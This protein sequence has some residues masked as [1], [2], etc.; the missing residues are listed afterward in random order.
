MTLTPEEGRKLHVPTPLEGRRI[1][2]SQAAEALGVSPWQVRRLRVGIRRDGLEAL[3]HGTRKRHAPAGD[4][5]QL[6]ATRARDGL[7]R[8]RPGGTPASTRMAPV[9]GTEPEAG[10]VGK[11]GGQRKRPRSVRGKLAAPVDK[12]GVFEARRLRGFRRRNP[13]RSPKQGNAYV[14]ITSPV[15]FDKPTGSPPFWCKLY[16]QSGARARNKKMHVGRTR[17]TFSRKTPRA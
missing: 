9:P 10:D 4:D 3:V 5:V 7:G 16:V 1:S 6:A 12:A 15:Q 8:L 2:S 14:T 13:W 11:G 17:V